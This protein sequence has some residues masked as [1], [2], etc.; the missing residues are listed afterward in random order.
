MG[1]LNVPIWWVEGFGGVLGWVARLL[2]AGKGIGSD[3]Y[4][5]RVL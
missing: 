3:I 5:Y 1:V 4:E 2:G